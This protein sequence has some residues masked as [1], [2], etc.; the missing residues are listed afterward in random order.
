MSKIKK[1]S[2]VLLVMGILMN[3]SVKVSEASFQLEQ[4]KIAHIVVS[5]VIYDVAYTYC[6]DQG[7][8][9][10]SSFC[11]A[12]LVTAGAGIL[13]EEMDDVFD[14]EDLLADGIGLVLGI[15]V[16]EIEF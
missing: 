4:D 14:H 13:K 5:A 10:F 3:S 11:Y 2:L 8:S 16:I 12:T 6:E 1:I 9:K 15:A 7:L